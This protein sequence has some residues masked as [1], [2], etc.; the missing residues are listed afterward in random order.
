MKYYKFELLLGLEEKDTVDAYLFLYHLLLKT[1]KD[2][3]ID[4]M[5]V[6][7]ENDIKDVDVSAALDDIGAA[8]EKQKKGEC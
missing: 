4:H 7:P 5:L 6:K 8:L 2:L 3:I 1:K